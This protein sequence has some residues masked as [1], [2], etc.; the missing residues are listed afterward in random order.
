[1]SSIN[2]GLLAFLNGI[3]RMEVSLLCIIS[4]KLLAVCMG[5]V[6]CIY[7]S[8]DNPIKN[9]LTHWYGCYCF[10]CL[11][12]LLLFRIAHISEINKWDGIKYVARKNNE[13]WFYNFTHKVWDSWSFTRRFTVALFSNTRNEKKHISIRNKLEMSNIC[14]LQ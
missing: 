8:C 12:L 4:V 6:S 5:Q 3:A 1:M 11:V 2:P 9:H 10:F 7:Y 13:S 14:D